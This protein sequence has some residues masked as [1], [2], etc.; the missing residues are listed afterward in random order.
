MLGVADLQGEL[1]AHATLAAG[2]ELAPVARRKLDLVNQ[3]ARPHRQRLDVLTFLEE[4]GDDL[5]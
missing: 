3:R 4:E 1:V 5:D 2:P